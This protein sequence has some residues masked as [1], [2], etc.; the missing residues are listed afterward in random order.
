MEEKAV[1]IHRDGTIAR[2]FGEPDGGGEIRFSFLK[3]SSQFFRFS[4]DTGPVP[5]WSVLI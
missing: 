1:G 4:F 3:S 5:C 2:F